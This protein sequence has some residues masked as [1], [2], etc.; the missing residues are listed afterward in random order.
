MFSDIIQALIQ[1]RPYRAGL[2]RD[3]VLD[4]LLH[5]ASQQTIFEPLM[6]IVMKDY[7]LCAD[8]ANGRGGGDSFLGGH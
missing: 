3:Q 5:L 6:K 4:I 7:E 8:V 1:D 2:S